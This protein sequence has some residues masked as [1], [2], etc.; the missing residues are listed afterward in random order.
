M[1]CFKKC[2]TLRAGITMMLPLYFRPASASFRRAVFLH[3][4]LGFVM[5]ERMLEP[6]YCGPMS[7]K[8]F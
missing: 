8:G 7:T 6:R 5:L 2:M 3:V 1:S 4:P